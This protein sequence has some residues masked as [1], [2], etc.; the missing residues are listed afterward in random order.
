MY[1][2]NLNGSDTLG[3]KLAK[4]YLKNSKQIGQKLV[5]TKVA[6]SAEDVNAVLLNGFYHLYGPI[7]DY[8]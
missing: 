2:K 3:A 5:D 1:F 4:A 7:N 6:K 8:V